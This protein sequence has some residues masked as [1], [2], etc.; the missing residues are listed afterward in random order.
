MKG[1]TIHPRQAIRETLCARLK[2]KTIAADRVFTQRQTPL[3]ESELPCLL[4]YTEAENV[5]RF[6]QSPRELKRKLSVILEGIVQARDN[7]DD[8]LDHFAAQ[9]EKILHRN[10]T[11]DD[12]VS[13][14][15]LTQTTIHV[16]AQGNQL[17]GSIVLTYEFIYYDRIPV[18]NFIE[19]V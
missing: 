15:Q 14:S 5:E 6:L 4:I 12:H 1:K 13:D 18:K 11:L 19:N 9:I 3:F 8:T 2:N 7:I 17:T 16:N 10:P